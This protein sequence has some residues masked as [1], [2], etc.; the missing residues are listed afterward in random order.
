M[1]DVVQMLGVRFCIDVGHSQR[2]LEYVDSFMGAYDG[3]DQDDQPEHRTIH[4]SIVRGAV[5]DCPPTVA[6]VPVHRSKHAYWTFDGR[7]LSTS[8]PFVSWPTRGVA[9]RLDRDVRHVE[10]VTTG[11]DHRFD[12]ESI[13]HVLR[14]LTLYLRAPGRWLL[15]AS[16]VCREGRCYAFTGDAFAGKTTLFTEAVLRGRA[17]PVA[18]D[19]VSIGPALDV[20]SWPSYASYCEGTLL[21]YPEL[22]AAALAYESERCPF[23]TQRW[24]GPLSSSF[25]KFKK[26]IYPMAWF[27]AA[28]DRKYRRHAPL[29]ALF[30]S[31]VDQSAR[32][33]SLRRM[34]LS[35][36]AD[37]ALFLNAVTA[38]SF[39]SEEPSFMPW[40]GLDRPRG[41]AS[42]DLLDSLVDGNA[43]VHY[44]S[45]HPDDLG[46]LPHL[47]EGLA[48]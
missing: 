41:S 14:S 46:S 6:S 30:L 15:H 27:A 37:R 18:N 2:V 38:G 16:A 23:R 8:P 3:R 31:K 1:T 34:D 29:G 22:V 20:L 24:S 33:P 17:T 47:L 48:P 36:A 26:R 5:P 32:S 11:N 45:I 9:V 44:L 19:R 39:E 28:A 12:G 40:H 21:R 13:F 25:S 7:V 35:A 43:P 4:V 42:E 10:V